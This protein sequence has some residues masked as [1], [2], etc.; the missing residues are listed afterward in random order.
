MKVVPRT[1]LRSL[2]VGLIGLVALLLMVFFVALFFSQQTGPGRMGMMEPSFLGGERMPLLSANISA[3]AEKSTWD[4]GAVDMMGGGRD[5]MDRAD[6]L[7][8]MMMERDSYAAAVPVVQDRKI[9]KNGTLS[10]QVGSVDQVVSEANM[11]AHDLGGMVADSHFTQTLGGIKSGSLMVRVAVDKFDEAFVRLKQL[12]TVVTSENISGSDLTAQYI[13]LQARINNQRA[14]ESALQNLLQRAVKVSDVIEVTDKLT[15]VRSE[16]ES[17]EGQM[18]YLSGQTDLA[19]I[20]LYVT[21]DVQAVSTT[22]FRPGQTLKESVVAL[23]HMIG[24]FV[25]SAI[26]FLIVGVPI[27]L[28][29]GVLFWLIYRLARRMVTTFWPGSLEEK[30][31]S[32]R[33]R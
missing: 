7:P 33:K 23:A 2:G 22:G 25:E 9:A 8:D 11:V 18:R 14:A 30:K 27:L 13:D 17:L 10:L 24:H 29:N 31:R 6:G 1:F 32:V 4:G 21:E 15:S 26:R 28:V 5:M 12:A 20:T 16:I 3:T 19:T